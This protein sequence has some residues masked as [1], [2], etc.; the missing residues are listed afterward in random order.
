MSD[1]EGIICL[2]CSDNCLN[3]YVKYPLKNGSCKCVYYMSLNIEK[4][5]FLFYF[6]YISFYISCIIMSLKHI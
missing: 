5:S 3:N 1:N 6:I 2:I 4:Q